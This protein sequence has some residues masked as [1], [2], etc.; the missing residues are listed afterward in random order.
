MPGQ[1]PRL[2]LA[3]AAAALLV[4]AS[5]VSSAAQLAQLETP[6]IRIVYIEATEAFLVPHAA[7]AF[8]N[9]WK[10]QKMLFDYT[11]SE[12]PTVLLIDLSDY[13]GGAAGSVPRN[14]VRVQIAPMNYVFETLPANERLTMLAN[15]ELVHV[16]TMDQAG[17]SDRAFRRLFFGKVLPI[18][19]QP[20]SIA[21][22]YL[23][24]PRVA[25]PR[26][27]I[28]GIA[29]FIETWMGA[30]LGRAQGG[31]DEMVFRAMVKDGS[32][33]Y[34]PLGLVAEGTRIDFHVE[35]NSY[36]Y[37][38]RFMTWLAYEH[39]PEKLI[40]WVSRRPGSR[41]YFA[42]QFRH[43]FG[44]SLESAWA[45]W[46]AFEQTFQ[47]DNLAAIRRFPVTPFTDLSRRALGSISRA[48]HD[49]SSGRIYAALNYPG[50]VAHIGAVSTATGE[51]EALVDVK[52]PRIYE[53][54][55]LAF[56]PVDNVLFY[57]NDNAAYRD[58]VRLDLATGRTRVLQ[59]DL[60]VG[61][62]VFNHADRSLW[63][64]RHLHGI[65]SI[66]RM[67][68]PYTDWR[69]VV[70][71]PYGVGVYDLDI[72][73]DG[74]MAAAVF[75]DVSGR[76]Q[77]RVMPMEALLQGDT[78][79]IASFDFDI[80]IPNGFVFSPDG[81]YLYGSAYLTGV[82][83][84]FRYEIATKELEAVT[85]AET[86]F[87]NPIPL[88]NDEL[89]VFRYSG[90]GFVP[91]RLT[92]TPLEDLGNITFLGERTVARHAVLKS[93]EVASLDSVQFETL[94]KTTRPY[95]L[96]G[97]LTLESLYPIVQGYK[98][99]AAVGLRADFS[100]PLRLN[101]ANLS[102]AF[103]PDRG[104]PARERLHVE[105]QYERY[106]WTAHASWNGADFYDL[107]GPTKSS[108]KGYSIGVGRSKTLIYDEPKQLD[109]EVNTR[110]AGS[111]DQLPQ[112][113]NVAVRV[114]KL[115][116]INADLNYTFTRASLG[117]VDAEKGQ[118]ASL[119]FRGDYVNSSVFTRI[120]GTWDAG[121]AL[122]LAHSSIWVRTAAGFSPQDRAEPFANFFFGGFGNN[123]VDHL[124]EKRYRQYYSF[125][126][127]ELNEVAGRN[128]V[129]TML[130]WNLPPVRF[131]RVGTPG[132][133][134]S[135]IRPALF[136]SGLV[137]NLDDESTRRRV[138]SAGAQVDLRFTVLSQIDLTLSAGAGVAIER[139]RPAAREAMVS[140]RVMR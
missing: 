77:V 140:L 82:S 118:R 99:T 134:L 3:V 109:L 88:G 100:D 84:V 79:G 126:G 19:E 129:R 4:V 112:Y 21:Y 75:G 34:D 76:Q 36:L 92:A 65:A 67:E 97:G 83:N 66:V 26:W 53:V 32:R 33:F 105:A 85:N 139:G 51:V 8:L 12:R 131:S 9:S 31:Y 35:A 29:V 64:V 44:R 37:G 130:E 17:G 7:R 123:Y 1:M 117:A 69:R 15:H 28:E 98:D 106:D 78:S 54:A 73:R 70:S 14:S 63:G 90:E 128:F 43:V 96:S 110:F 119:A 137:T 41:A 68:A 30:G 13:G 115:F 6:D 102:V 27:Y 52:G 5:P 116:S 56:D 136:V 25:A 40:E 93:W 81:R 103:S 61:D 20:E 127:K 95:H 47:A 45:D 23:T 124:N 80:A 62:L 55:S 91:A 89:I 16:A 87:F 74:T 113:Q 122:P 108:R 22:F 38:G 50:R 114:D 107:F 94:E 58:L 11:P 10:F 132:A 125:P 133:Y 111:L 138:A 60:R 72:S 121:A 104:L 49:A 24:S 86:G 48:Y 59:K 71:L 18:P 46:I 120:Y 39:T 57:T 2:R 42:S 135:W 101:N